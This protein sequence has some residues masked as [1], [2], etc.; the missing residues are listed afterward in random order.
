MFA[1][2]LA[3]RPAHDVPEEEV[4][5]LLGYPPG[6]ELAGDARALADAAR[7]WSAEH[8]RPRILAELLDVTGLDAATT[9]W[10]SPHGSGAFRSADLARRLADA[11]AHGLFAVAVTAGPELERE[12]ERLGGTGDQVEAAFL[13]RFAA[14]LVEWLVHAAGLELERVAAAEGA[15]LLPPRSPGREDWQ[16]EDQSRLLGAF[17]AELPDLRLLSSGMLVPRNSLLTVFGLTRHVVPHGAGGSVPC[18]DCS[19]SPC[20]FRRA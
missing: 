17:D 3:E 18:A 1:L 6:R 16:L 12:L 13:D 10:R 11:R 7:A 15:S 14:A 9:Q 20:A 4:A 8:A 2:A 5:R 19:W